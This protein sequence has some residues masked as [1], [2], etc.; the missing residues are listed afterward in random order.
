MEKNILI[1]DDSESIRELLGSTLESFGYKVVKGIN[2]QDGLKQLENSNV[3]LIIS[4]VNMPVMDG[5]EMVKEIRSKAAYKYVPIIMLTTE[6]QLEKKTE[7]KNA[8][9]TGWIVK[10]FDKDRLLNVIKKVIR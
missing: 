9:A 6:S 10:P 4:D 3:Q 5:I 8:G 7:A 2:G 1:V